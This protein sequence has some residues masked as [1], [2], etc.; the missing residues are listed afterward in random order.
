MFEPICIRQNQNVPF[1]R[2]MH[3]EPYAALVQPC[4]ETLQRLCQY[5]QW[6]YGRRFGAE[7]PGLDQGKIVK[8]TN[9]ST[10]VH[11]L[12]VK[13]IQSLPCDRSDTVL[14][15]LYFSAKNSQG[16]SQF[17]RYV[18]QPLLL[19]L[20]MFFQGLRHCIETGGQLAQFIMRSDGDSSVKSAGDSRP[21]SLSPVP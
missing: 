12:E 8:V 16:G 5:L 4:P 2:F 13:R 18:H 10:Q 21:L 6:I 17:V 14:H 15:G 3:I 20:L 7:V 1:H 9:D 11:H 19:R